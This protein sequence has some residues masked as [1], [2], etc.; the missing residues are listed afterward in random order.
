MET[1]TKPPFRCIVNADLFRRAMCCISKEPTRYYLNGV[2][3]E[4]HK[5]GG[6]LLVS[7]D[8]HRL[9][10]IRDK[11]AFI[12]GGTA[13]IKPRKWIARAL[14]DKSTLPQFI[15]VSGAT[16]ALASETPTIRKPGEP[17]IK[18]VRDNDALLALPTKPDKNV[19]AMQWCDVIIDGKFPDWR[20]VVPKQIIDDAPIGEFNAEQLRSLGAAL[21]GVARGTRVLASSK[22]AGHPHFV[23]SG[24]SE[25][26]GFGI[27]LPMRAT[28]TKSAIPAWMIEPEPVVEPVVVVEEAPAKKSAN[29][30][31]ELAALIKKP[32]KNRAPKKAAT[33]KAA[34]PAR[35]KPARQAAVTVRRTP[36]KKSASKPN[37][38][39][40]R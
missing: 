34:P 24:C 20:R 26:D 17:Y 33:K 15:V 7:T 18:H 25:V 11:D 36:A 27:I 6:A 10:V 3:I 28:T 21:A 35:K 22:D 39:K 30:A 19:R 9:I 37:V 4:P 8:G 40:A 31:P 32:V 12:E 1:V 13:I 23:F 29:L 38:R 14:D 2:H 5:D 16:L